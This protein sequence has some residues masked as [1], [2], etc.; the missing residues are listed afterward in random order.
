VDKWTFEIKPFSP[1]HQA[2]AEAL[3]SGYRMAK[4]KE[5]VHDATSDGITCQ[6][7][8]FPGSDG[9]APETLTFKMPRTKSDPLGIL[10]NS[11]VYIKSYVPAAVPPPLPPPPPPKLPVILAVE[12]N[13]FDTGNKWIPRRGDVHVEIP[14]IGE[15]A[16]FTREGLDKGVLAGE[17]AN[18]VNED[19][20]AVDPNT[21][22]IVVGDGMGGRPLP[23]FKNYYAGGVSSVRGYNTSSLGPRDPSDNSIV[24]GNRRLV[25]NAE[26][27]FPMPGMAGDRSVR[28]GAFVDGGQVFASGDKIALADL[29]YA[30]GLSLAWNSPVGPLKFSVAK[31]LNEKPGD[32][33]QRLQFTLGQIF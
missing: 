7:E 14:G 12:G 5:V 11:I 2:M 9:K 24:G 26:L 23:F 17:R 27:L 18:P 10:P 6:I 8:I 1:D 30:A 33:I 32:N 4:V 28:L 25:G 29:R 22:L 16:G 31:P 3:G 19:V 20:F 13:K 15:V 21:G